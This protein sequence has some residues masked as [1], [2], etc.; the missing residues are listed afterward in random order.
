MSDNTADHWKRLLMVIAVLAG[1]TAC[2]DVLM[3]A[4]IHLA[5]SL[6]LLIGVVAFQRSLHFHSVRWRTLAWIAF[7]LA[8]AVQLVRVTMV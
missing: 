2:M 6:C 1:I 5:S 7:V 8:M 3:G 4:W